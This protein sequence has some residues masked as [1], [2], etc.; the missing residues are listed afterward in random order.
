MNQV[1]LIITLRNGKIIDRSIPE[2]CEDN[3]NEN[4][5]GKEGLNKLKP[6]EEITIVPFEPPFLHALN[7]PRK[8]NHFFKIYEIFK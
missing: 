7:K 4:S 8:S 3:D 2:P 6:I 5:K 1:K